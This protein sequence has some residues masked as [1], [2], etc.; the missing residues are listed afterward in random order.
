MLQTVS[1]PNVTMV[2]TGLLLG[3]GA[4]SNLK[5]HGRAMNK[6]LERWLRGAW[7]VGLEVPLPS[8][9]PSPSPEPEPEPEPEPSP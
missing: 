8:P 1:G 6:D 2:I 3:C 7:R 9:S 5:S 4:L